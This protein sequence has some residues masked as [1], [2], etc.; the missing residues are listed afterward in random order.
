MNNMP[1]Q[2]YLASSFRAPGVAD[3][4]MTD[5]EKQLGKSPSEIKLSYIITAGN[6]HPEGSRDWI[7]EGRE[8]LSQRGWQIFDY[9]IAGKTETEVTAELSDKDVIF[10]QG[11]QCIYMLEECQKC[12]FAEII[13][14]A[15]MRGALYIGE[16]TGAILT[17][18]DI[19]P[20]TYLSKDHRENPP[21]LDSYQGFGLVNFLVR[22]HWNSQRKGEAY[23]NAMINNMDKYFS[24]T[25]PIICLNDN[26]LIR[27]DG[28]SFQIWE[29]EVQLPIAKCD[30]GIFLVF[31]VIVTQHK[32][33]LPLAKRLDW[34]NCNFLY[35]LL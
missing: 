30:N 28:N 19:S 18:N 35:L 11:G 5:V 22:P 32:Y 29:A 4:I 31:G 16:S 21:V 3:L 14:K 15:L 17:G 25:E 10:V 1:Q 20:Y 12:N 9:D 34:K 6:L 8:F 26:Q 27:V 33:A 23:K 2:L 24:I 7:V 13:K